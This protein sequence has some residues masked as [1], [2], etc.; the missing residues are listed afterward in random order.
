M[1]PGSSR[2]ILWLGSGL[3]MIVVAVAAPAQ[4][5]E[6]GVRAIVIHIAVLHPVGLFR[7][8]IL[9]HARRESGLQQHRRAECA[10]V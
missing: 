2:I 1:F 5:A 10:S 8:M 4:A 3:L 7:I 9:V 6:S